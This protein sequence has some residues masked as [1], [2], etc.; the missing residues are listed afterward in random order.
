MIRHRQIRLSLYEFISG[1]LPA[2]AQKAVESHLDTCAACRRELSAIRSAMDG[3]GTP[4]KPSDRLPETYWNTFSTRVEARLAG[5][6][7]RRA[8]PP[9]ILESLEALLLGNRRWALAAGGS[10]LA[11]GLL[12]LFLQRGPE[13]NS[14]SHEHDGSAA[15]LTTD[16]QIDHVFRRSRALL[17]GID[18]LRP[19]GGGTLDLSAEQHVSRELVTEARAL[20]NVPLNPRSARMVRDLERI[21]IGLANT[22]RRATVPEVDIIRNGMRQENILFRLRMAEAGGGSLVTRQ[23]RNEGILQ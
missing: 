3:T 18:N 13:V 14:L 9:M 21:L 4:E 16:Q 2:D 8:R 10:A 23:I 17:V 12:L 6:G 1:E 22:D 19:A 7:R 20:R 15:V 11:V 5:P